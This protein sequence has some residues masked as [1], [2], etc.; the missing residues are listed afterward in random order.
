MASMNAGIILA[1]Q[2]P[3]LLS[4]V[5]NANTAAAQQNQFQRT[6]DLNA[7]YKDQGAQIAAGEQGALNALARFD[8][9]AALGV[10]GARQGLA[11]GDLAMDATR[12]NM[13]VQMAT[14]ARLSRAEERQIQVHAANMSEQ[15]RIAEAAQIERGV[16]QAMGA[17]TP[18]EFDAIV[19][20]FDPTLVGQ[21]GN[22]E[23][24]AGKYLSVADMLK[25]ADSQAA[26]AAS[27]A[28][29]A[30]EAERLRR[31]LV[32]KNAREDQ[33]RQQ[34]WDREDRI[35]EEKNAVPPKPADEYQRYVQEESQAGRQPLSRI[36]YANAKRDKGT[37]V[38]DPATGKPLVSIGGASGGPTKLTEK[39]SQLALFGNMMSSTM[40]VINKLEQQF[41][42]SNLIDNLSARAGIAGNYTK[43]PE[44]RKY[45]TAAR[46]WGEGVLRIQTGAAA[47]QPEIQRVFETYFAQPGDQPE[48]IAFKRELRTAFAESIGIAG[49]GAVA[50]PGVET[51]GAQAQPDGP[52]APSGQFEFTNDAQKSVFEKYSQP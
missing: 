2:Q 36:D 8:P 19:A 16:S 33:L 31:Q 23:A 14:Q 13:Q 44:Y 9:N 51:D 47:T 32:T 3:N 30:A 17:Q 45:E 22:R 27:E 7:L 38:Y 41:D 39:Q 48:D 24:I 15:Q 5:A 43:S 28:A 29:A 35:R 6:N 21:F 52:A 1:G 49:G 40:P 26:S 12:Q 18:A 11:R 37:V 20:Q 4:T 50:I 34:E 10:Q 46:A 42:P 25:R